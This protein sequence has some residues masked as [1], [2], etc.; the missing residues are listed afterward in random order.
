M[1]SCRVG[2][3]VGA[4]GFGS[5][6]VSEAE[7]SQVAE[8]TEK[9]NEIIT[10][11]HSDSN[12]LTAQMDFVLQ[13]LHTTFLTIVPTFSMSISVNFVWHYSRKGFS[14]KKIKRI[15]QQH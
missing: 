2:V 5:L 9:Y 8:S 13:V 15:Q 12:Q 7:K 11:V 3:D 10:G 6:P 4:L 1:L 14:F